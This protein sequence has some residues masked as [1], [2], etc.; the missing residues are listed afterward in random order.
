M[1]NWDNL[2]VKCENKELLNKLVEGKTG[3]ENL[4]FREACLDDK[5][6]QAYFSV[7]NGNNWL[8]SFRLL[9]CIYKAE[10]KVFLTFEH[11]WH[12]IEHHLVF[13]NGNCEI[14]KIKANYMWGYGKQKVTYKQAFNA[15]GQLIE[16]DGNPLYELIPV[17]Q[18]TDEN[19][20][21]IDTYFRKIDKLD[22]QEKT[23]V[24][25]Q[26]ESDINYFDEYTIL[27]QFIFDDVAVSV[28]KTGPMIK[29][30]SIKSI[31]SQEDQADCPF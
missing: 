18:L 7:K 1:A 19:K 8:T 20:I 24:E 3:I 16:K 10:I 29:V 17:D 28:R 11:D 25:S 4:W 6:T 30:E 22:E 2:T 9:S 5:L 15:N 27:K 23:C 14:V 31:S 21:F 13:E 26:G 12:L